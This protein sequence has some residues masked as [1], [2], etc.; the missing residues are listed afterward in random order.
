MCTPTRQLLYRCAPSAVSIKNVCHV[1]W[2]P[3]GY[4]SNIIA[5]YDIIQ[6]PAHLQ[7]DY[8]DTRIK[9]RGELQQTVVTSGLQSTK[10]TKADP[11]GASH[12]CTCDVWIMIR[13]SENTAKTLFT[14]TINNM[15]LQNPENRSDKSEKSEILWGGWFAGAAF[16][17]TVGAALTRLFP[18][19]PTAQSFPELV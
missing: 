7:I 3:Y 10:V 13:I 11:E 5:T 16:F 9:R 2:D 6:H 17:A 4:Y 15:T 8:S 14:P 12:M 1:I 19:T 18:P